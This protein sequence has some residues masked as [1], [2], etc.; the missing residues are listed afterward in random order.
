MHD[1]IV[2]VW[3]SGRESWW[4][5]CC[6]MAM[7]RAPIEKVRTNI[8]GQI[9]PIWHV[10][11]HG[12]WFFRIVIN[13]RMCWY[14]HGS[15]WLKAVVRG[16]GTCGYWWLNLNRFN[17]VAGSWYQTWCSL[18]MTSVLMMT[19]SWGLMRYHFR[20]GWVLLLRWIW[21]KFERI[22]VVMNGMAFGNRWIMEGSVVWDGK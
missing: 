15:W 22:Q 19:R 20:E 5:G 14:I 7:P 9:F 18:S 3:P 2:V 1:Q 13:T 21:S 10:C 6:G 4:K 11:D 8:H 12:M 17:T 16:Y